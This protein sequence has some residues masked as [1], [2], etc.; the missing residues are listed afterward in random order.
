MSTQ[1]L[2]GVSLYLDLQKK[3]LSASVYDESAWS[4]LEPGRLTSMYAL[5]RAAAIKALDKKS[6]LLVKV[7]PYDHAQRKNGR[8]LPF[9]GFTMVG[10]RR[11]D[12]IRACIE[13]VIANNIPGDF[14]ECGVWRGG[15]SIFAK[16]VF[17][18]YGVSNRKVWL[19]DS[20]EGMPVLKL[21]ADKVDSDYSTQRYFAVSREVVENNFRKFDLL[22]E[23]VRFVKGWFSESLHMASIEQIAV[24][25]LDA[26]HYS[27]TMDALNAL[28]G[29]MST[30]GF[31]IVDDYNSFAGC[32]AAV[33]EFRAVRGITSELIGIDDFGVYWRHGGR[34][35][36]AKRPG[37]DL[38]DET[39]ASRRC[40]SSPSIVVTIADPAPSSPAHQAVSMLGG[41]PSRIFNTVRPPLPLA[42]ETNQ[43]QK[44]L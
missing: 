27:S 44:P 23:N 19:A 7:R 17:T 38:H 26:D 34:G 21:E 5:I 11:L 28:H 36:I 13:S 8:D 10:H 20:F 29:K 33:T 18:A 15:S 40:Q 22:D 9:L 14:V 3:T 24:L 16:G 2:G 30:G 25:R 1:S 42:R 31:V 43:S 12:N 35:S 39:S 41:V 4:V 37:G 32:K 6:V